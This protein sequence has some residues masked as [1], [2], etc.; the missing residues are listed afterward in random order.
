MAT[1]DMW[2]GLILVLRDAAAG[3]MLPSKFSGLGHPKARMLRLLDGARNDA[4]LQ[5]R[6]KVM[7]IDEGPHVYRQSLS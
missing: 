6:L 2:I 4:E 5:S 1:E 7:D 3:F